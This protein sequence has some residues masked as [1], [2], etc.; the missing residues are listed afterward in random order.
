MNPEVKPIELAVVDDEPKEKKKIK[1]KKKNARFRDGEHEKGFQLD[2]GEFIGDASWLE[3]CQGCFLHT[4]K[5][6]I[7]ISFSVILILLCLYCFG[8]GLD[9]LGSG[10]KVVTSCAAG[11]LF[12]H[13]A[14]PVSSLTIGILAT[15]L[16][17][18]SS[19]TTSI[20]VGLVG[21]DNG[22]VSV[23][24]GIYMM[25]G[26]N[27]GTTVTNTIVSLG[28]FS[29]PEQLGHAFA[30]ATIH[31]LFNFMSVAVLFPIEIC[32]GYL[33]E[34][35]AA[36]VRGANTEQ[37]EAWE[38]PA[39]KLISPLAARI[40]IANKKVINSVA[41]GGDCDAFYPV[42]CTDPNNPTY[43]TCTRV[44]L[45]TCDKHTGLCP[46]FF[47]PDAGR[48]ED[49]VSGFVVF[50][51]GLFVIFTSLFALAFLIQKLL[52]GVS[53]RV[54]YKATA[55]NSYLLIAIGAGIT[56][57]LQSSSTT[58][59]FLTPIVGVGAMRL[60]QMFALTIGANIGTT[61]TALLAALVTDGN[62]SLQVALAHL[63]FN[64]NG[65][66]IWYPIPAIREIPLESARRLGKAAKAW[67]GFT[68]VYIAVMFF[69]V[70]G[71]LLGLSAVFTAGTASLTVVGY[72]LTS[73]LGILLLV[74][75]RWMYFQGGRQRVYDTMAAKQMR[76]RAIQTLPDDMAKVQRKL[77]RL[78]EYADLSPAKKSSSSGAP[79]Y[80]SIGRGWCCCYDRRVEEALRNL[81]PNMKSAE[82][83]LPILF[84]HLGVP[85]E[86]EA[87]EID[88]E[89]A[90]DEDAMVESAVNEGASGGPA[91][92][93]ATATHDKSDTTAEFWK[94]I[95]KFNIACLVCGIPLAIY[96][97]VTLFLHDSKAAK[98]AAGFLTI[99][100]GFASL[101][102]LQHWVYKNGR[103]CWL[104][105]FESKE[106]R[107]AAVASLPDDMAEIKADIRRLFIHYKM[108]PDEK[109][110][111]EQQQQRDTSGGDTF[112]GSS[113]M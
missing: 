45:I 75:V 93:V 21:A 76:F 16:I 33:F 4:P 101:Y 100:L 98:G 40:L 73:F 36:L 64:V 25:M 51:I 14:N 50:F 67:R 78:F 3:V 70:P 55:I 53:I 102:T 5:E 57:L 58:T 103:E 112:D 28:H 111:K 80:F 35:T 61:I 24:Q 29:N 46:A 37:G 74:S 85:E 41:S 9:F 22:I 69:I 1:K 107:D 113:R 89:I 106:R 54:I 84:H 23:Q 90:S 42:Q 97:L 2:N 49:Q 20:I 72:L 95:P 6:W 88:I 105:H 17:Q 77:A 92:K 47:S 108:L 31:D 109:D 38:G 94:K 66:M 65:M 91:E 30:G 26:A 79:E 110:L 32:T 8:L 99:L 63:M 56:M 19:T 34:L 44:G 43:L 11:E 10:A 82:L 15:V 52:K 71:T 27:I 13:N 12:G 60:E 87:E 86:F 39:K 7:G 96:G 81:V 83:A 48:F 68:L 18:S 59:S 62:E 104:E